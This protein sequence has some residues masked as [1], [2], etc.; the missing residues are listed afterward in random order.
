MRDLIKHKI[1]AAEIAFRYRELRF[2]DE[3]T[4]IGPSLG[5]TDRRIVNYH[6]SLTSL[7]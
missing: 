2:D 4:F 1:H 7:L 3:W 5:K 6:P